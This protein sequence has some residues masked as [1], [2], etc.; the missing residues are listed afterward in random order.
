MANNFVNRG[1]VLTLRAQHT[2]FDGMPYREFG[3]NGVALKDADKG[4]LYTFQIRGVFEFNLQGV[5]A[6]DLIYLLSCNEL[7]TTDADAVL[8]L[9]GHFYGRAVTDS[10]EDGTFQCLILQ[11]E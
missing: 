9:G 4:E 1:E 11:S 8:D 5:K 6:G 10:D 3:F 2:R 7:L